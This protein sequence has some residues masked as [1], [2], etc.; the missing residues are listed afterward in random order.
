MLREVIERLDDPSAEVREEAARALGSIGSREATEALVGRLSDPSSPIRIEAARA[1][2]DIGDERAVPALVRCLAVGSPELRAAC[3]EALGSIGGEAARTRSR[4]DP[5][6][7][8]E[9]SVVAM[10]AEAVTKSAGAEEA[11]APMEVLEAVQELFP[12][13]AEARNAALKRQ[14]AIA[15]GNILGQA[16]RVLP[17]HHRR[18]LVAPGALPRPL[19]LVQAPRRAGPRGVPRSPRPLDE[20]RPGHRGRARTRGPGGLPAASMAWS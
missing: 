5:L 20:L 14:Y 12:R 3:A 7:E 18:G 9:H 15:L 1:L 11:E 17:L 4:A 6:G 2:G 13:F 19:R 8:E 16:G 10:L